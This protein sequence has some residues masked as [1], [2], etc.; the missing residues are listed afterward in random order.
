MSE[1]LDLLRQQLG[2][3]R[4]KQISSELGADETST[5]NAMATA[6]PLLIGGLDRNA[7]SSREGAQSLN[8]ALEEDHDGSL[9]DQLG[10]LLGGASGLGGGGGLLG[11]AASLLGGGGGAGGLLGS[12]LGGGGNTRATNS[13][14][15]LRHVLGNKRGAVESGV[16]R[17]SGLDAQKVSTLLA[18]L[19]PIVMSSLGRVKR[20][21][22]LGPD[23]VTALLNRER[24]ELEQATP[25]KGQGG[26][27]SMLDSNNDGQ[28]AD[29][30]AKMGSSLS[31]GLL[32][33]LLGR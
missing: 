6:L 31:G 7:S 2:G 28:I 8:T 19:A 24:T 12:L 32:G 27:L 1:L 20:Q 4:V 9:L 3:D 29:D 5:Q 17:A 22:N 15:I 25:Q 13:D 16:S 23:Q 33:K 10:G 11:A 18:L 30:I 26:L 14:A 21:Q